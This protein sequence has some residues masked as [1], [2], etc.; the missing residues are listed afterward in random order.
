MEKRI[1]AKVIRDARLDLRLSMDD[2][3]KEVG[4]SAVH[5]SHIEAGRAKP[6]IELAVRIAE[7]LGFDL[8]GIIFKRYKSPKFFW[9]KKN[10]GLGEKLYTKPHLG[11]FS[12]IIRNRRIEM[13]IF[14]KDLA[15]MVGVSPAAMTKWEAGITKPT[16]ENMNKLIDIL[17]LERSAL[18]TD[19]VKRKKSEPDKPDGYCELVRGFEEHSIG[20]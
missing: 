16:R 17:Q 14:S 2:I 12:E 15:K 20:S 3:A 11:S 1:F 5:F 4:C 10:T 7:V 18:K 13:R 8:R 9:A 19:T 6:S